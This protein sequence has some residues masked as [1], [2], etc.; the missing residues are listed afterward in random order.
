M[1]IRI[2][3]RVVQEHAYIWGLVDIVIMAKE[4]ENQ[5]TPRMLNGMVL[6]MLR[7]KQDV[8]PILSDKGMM[9]RIAA[10]AAKR[11][12]LLMSERLLVTGSLF[13]PL[14]QKNSPICL[15]SISW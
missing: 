3:R 10:F 4:K 1:F 9:F 6:L 7:R 13:L 14:A 5:L 2:G 11:N 8:W 15:K 12:R